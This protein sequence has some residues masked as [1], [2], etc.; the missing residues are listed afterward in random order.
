MVEELKGGRKGRKD[1][2]YPDYSVSKSSG[3]LGKPFDCGNGGNYFSV[4]NA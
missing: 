3:R 4:C 2:S 1:S